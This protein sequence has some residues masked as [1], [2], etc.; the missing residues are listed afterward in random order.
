MQYDLRRV[1]QFVEA[2]V[3]QKP[4]VF[5][6]LAAGKVDAGGRLVDETSRRFIGDQMRALVDLVGRVQRGRAAPR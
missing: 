4:E 5:I 3:L 2:E 1:L 6:G